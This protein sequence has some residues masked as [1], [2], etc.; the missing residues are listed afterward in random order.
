MSAAGRAGGNEGVS[1][2][3]C[4][5][6][7]AAG[8][9]AFAIASIIASAAQRGY[10]PWQEDIS[11]LAA[12][13]AQNPWIMITGFLVLSG[14]TIALAA[15]LR[16]AIQP[17]QAATAGP[18]MILFVGVGIAALGLMRND[19]STELAT[20]A[21]RV[22]TGNVSWHHHGHDVVSIIVF[23]TLMLAPLV[24][25]EAFRS[26]PRWRSLRTYSRVT[27]ALSLGLFALYILS[28]STIPEWSGLVQ[29]L[30]TTATLTWLAVLGTRLAQPLRARI[31]N[32]TASTAE[33]SLPLRSKLGPWAE[34]RQAS[35]NTLHLGRIR[36]PTCTRAP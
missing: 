9:L 6:L 1:R 5:Y 35:G 15:G 28:S 7:G 2:R 31:S 18:I 3:L 25:A 29:R 10:N 23:T 13:D 32:A 12:L 36:E 8:P 11:A 20:C 34:H 16:G 26:E 19:C 14:C 17:S 27:A 22:R 24:F 21:A 4:G 33:P 30:F